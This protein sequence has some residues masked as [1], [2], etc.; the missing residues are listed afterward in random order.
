MA[1][2]E[3]RSFFWTSI[4]VAL[5]LIGPANAAA[6]QP[7]PQLPVV[8]EAVEVVATRIPETPHEVPAAIEVV[9]GHTLRAMNARTLPQALA[10]AAGV[11]VTQGGDA[12]PAGSVPE[13]RGLREFDA[14]LLVV[15][16][17]PWGGAFNPAL[18]TINLRDVER[19]EILRG[20]APVTFGATSFVGVIHV[21][22]KAGA[23]SSKYVDVRAGS[24]GSGGAGADLALPAVG[25]WSSRLSIDGE[26]TGFKD[27]RTQFSRGHA[28]WRAASNG[29]D[30]KS[31]LLADV[32]WLHQDPASPFPREGRVLSTRVPLD[33]NHNPAGAFLDETRISVAY[34]FDRPLGDKRWMTTASFSHSAQDIFRGF[35]SSVSDAADNARGFRETIDVNDIYADSH[36][37]WPSRHRITLVAGGD[38]LVGTGDAKGATFGYTVPLSGGAGAAVAEPTTLPLG[39]DDRR[40]LT[41]G[42]G[43]L[44]WRPSPRVT[45]SGGLRV[46]MTFETRGGEEE[47]GAA[48][49]EEE[50]TQ[51]NVRP[52]GSAGAMVG[53][54][55]RGANHVRAYASFRSTFKP[56]AFD[57]GLGEEEGGEE[58]LL[59]PE[60][61]NNYETGLKVRA[62][63]GRTDFEADVFRLD[64]RNLVTSTVV[65]GLPALMNSGKTR[66]EGVEFAND[67]RLP[68]QITGRLTYSFHDAT[69]VDFVRAFD[70][71]PTQL[72]GKRFEVSPR[73][74]FGGG[75]V[76]APAQG[77]FGSFMARYVGSRYLDKRNRAVV[78]GYTTLEAGAGLRSGRW[79]IRIDGRN[80]GDRRDPV[81]ES[82]LGDAQ[83]YR[84][85]ARRVEATFG[86]RF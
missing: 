19:V 54:W 60:T 9:M 1:C 10:L 69:F 6:Q 8:N 15:D 58:A 31:W 33:A 79:E 67:W 75:I 42:Y 70:G 16:G 27:D 66:F 57:F 49:D 80:L 12:G 55:E 62:L 85:D 23:D 40:T 36:V 29:A 20:P 56:A 37:T 83:Y 38:L 71:V 25:S 84:L 22:H 5:L 63:G 78:P 59:E 51:T 26:R 52:S 35:L 64:F 34:G 68:K 76:Y 14:F 43:L 4:P 41:G 81:A 65:N 72:A 32:N 18:A 45:L 77:V 3:G 61:A 30:R 28:L 74:L 11:D 86:V 17:I 39:I 2:N 24:Y 46:N 48:A 73:H 7:D 47:A 21:V 53:L 82:E 50:A 44:E 13:F